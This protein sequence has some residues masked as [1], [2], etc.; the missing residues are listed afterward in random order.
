[1]PFIFYREGREYGVPINWLFLYGKLSDEDM[2]GKPSSQENIESGKRTCACRANLLTLGMKRSF[3]TSSEG[4]RYYGKERRIENQA[5]HFKLGRSA[6][7]IG[8]NYRT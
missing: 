4:E 8:F 2:I 6:I 1:V 3:I 5:Y 7:W